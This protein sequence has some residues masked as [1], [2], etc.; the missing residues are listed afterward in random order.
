MLQ[1]DTA[2]GIFTEGQ[3]F[4]GFGNSDILIRQVSV[5]SPTRLLVNVAISSGAQGGSAQLSVVSGLQLMAQQ[6]AFQVT[7]ASKAFWLSSNITNAQTGTAGVSPGAAAVLTIGNSS[8]ALSTSNVALFMN[9]RSIPI[10]SVANSQITF[11]LPSSMT[12]GTLCF[13]NRSQW[14]TKFARLDDRGSAASKDSIG[15]LR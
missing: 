13:T 12:P 14:R 6:F 15:I 3:T 10:T 7:P 8:T 5:I 11:N 1:I 9:D 4:V 2:G